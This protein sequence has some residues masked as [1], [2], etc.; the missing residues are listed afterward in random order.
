LARAL[1]TCVLLMLGDEAGDALARDILQQTI[2]LPS[3]DMMRTSRLRLDLFNI[4]FERRTFVRYTY[5]RYIMMDASR[6][7]G[8]EYYLMR[9]D[10]VRIPRCDMYDAQKL[11]LMDLQASFETRVC[12]ASTLG[13]GVQSLE[14]KALNTANVYLMETGDWD[15]FD[16]VRDQVAGVTTDQGTERLI[17]DST[18]RSVPGYPKEYQSADPR[19]FLFPKAWF[20]VQVG[21]FIARW[22][23]FKSIPDEARSNH[24]PTT[25]QPRS[26]HDPTTIR[27][28]SDHD[29]TTIQPR[30]NHDPTTIRPR[31][32]HDRDSNSDNTS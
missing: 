11:L 3:C 20:D 31:S 21:S 16:D 26:N 32:N 28:R 19:C 17:A 14:K 30:S 25:I 29:P 6:Q 13:K 18:V 15:K 4:L 5:F 9:E 1:A 27:P 24:D 10:R 23:R 7:S 22:A 12:P 2:P 8:H